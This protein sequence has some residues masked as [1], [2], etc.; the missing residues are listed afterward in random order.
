ML[1]YLPENVY[2]LLKDDETY[3]SLITAA[4]NEI[5]G[6]YDDF[7]QSIINYN[8]PNKHI[9]EIQTYILQKTNDNSQFLSLFLDRKPTP[10]NKDSDIL[11]Q[12]TYHYHY[13][14]SLIPTQENI[15]RFKEYIHLYEQNKNN[16]IVGGIFHIVY[17]SRKIILEILENS[18]SLDK[19]NKFDLTVYLKYENSLFNETL[20]L[21]NTKSLIDIL[22]L[23]RLQFLYM[24]SDYILQLR[25][26]ID[27]YEKIKELMDIPNYKYNTVNYFKLLF[28]ILF[29]QNLMDRRYIKDSKKIFNEII[30]DINYGITNK[31]YMIKSLIQYNK[32]F[33]PH[34]LQIIYYVNYIT[35]Y[36]LT[37]L[38]PSMFANN[39]LSNNEIDFLTNK[40]TVKMNKLYNYII[41][42]MPFNKQ[43]VISNKDAFIEL[44]RFFIDNE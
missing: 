38:K 9:D 12:L 35:K 14:N 20:S 28:K 3:N 4:E 44:N 31:E 25:F 5:F 39:N 26:N 22:Y 6:E 15:E 7:V 19:I 18:S 43:W 23:N 37:D 8:L 32:D 24:L 40:S 29:F 11:T 42:D 1:C 21:L 30:E 33:M 16:T 36:Y 13:N 27:E 41:T 34:F 2:E 17:Y 10:L